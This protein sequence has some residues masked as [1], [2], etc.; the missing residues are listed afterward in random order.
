MFEVRE[1]PDLVE[2]AMLV[3]FCFDKSEEPETQKLLIEL[4]E[5]VDTC[6]LY[7]SPSPRD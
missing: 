7:T 6:L 4:E 3:G 1:K 2:R 5:L